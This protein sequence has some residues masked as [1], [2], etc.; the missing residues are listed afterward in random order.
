MKDVIPPWK[1]AAK[2]VSI[3]RVQTDLNTF[4][5]TFYRIW[6]PQFTVIVKIYLLVSLWGRCT[7]FLSIKIDQNI[8]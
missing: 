3:H 8:N 1:S 7:Y 6:L 2:F 4:T 5:N